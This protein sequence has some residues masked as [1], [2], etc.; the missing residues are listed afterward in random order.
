M[1]NQVFAFILKNKVFYKTPKEALTSKQLLLA[2][3]V[4]DSNGQLIK[5]TYTQIDDV[6]LSA[7]KNDFKDYVRL[8]ID[9]NIINGSHL[10]FD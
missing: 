5:T 1:S 3:S 9:P 4:I 7:F 10:I 6:V 2:D 8:F